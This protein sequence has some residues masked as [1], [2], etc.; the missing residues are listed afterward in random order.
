MRHDP[1]VFARIDL[2]FDPGPVRADLPR[3]SRDVAG[4]ALPVRIDEQVHRPRPSPVTGTQMQRFDQLQHPAA[5]IVIDQPI[6]LGLNDDIDLMIEN[7]RGEHVNGSQKRGDTGPE[8]RHEQRGKARR[9]K[10]KIPGQPRV[11]WHRS[12][13]TGS[14]GRRAKSLHGGRRDHRGE[15]GNRG[16]PHRSQGLLRIHNPL[17]RAKS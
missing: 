7:P 8:N 1:A 5:T 15:E 6:H 11:I 10:T 14:P 4:D 3:P 12:E 13:Y 9:R 16:A 2:E 17:A